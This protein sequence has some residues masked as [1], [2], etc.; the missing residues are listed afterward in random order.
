MPS[1]GAGRASTASP[2]RYTAVDL[3]QAVT[4]A[5]M[6]AVG[7]VILVRTLPLGLHPQAL[8]A[9]FGFLGLGAYRLSFVVAYLRRRAAR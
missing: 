8:L 9:G 2:P 6:V 1:P 3:Y 7:L 5:A 4:S